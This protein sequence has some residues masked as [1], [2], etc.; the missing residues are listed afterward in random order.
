MQ[1][2]GNAQTYDLLHELTHQRINVSMHQAF[3]KFIPFI[4]KFVYILSMAIERSDSELYA[5]FS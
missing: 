1:R 3:L 2:Y 5:L 4:K